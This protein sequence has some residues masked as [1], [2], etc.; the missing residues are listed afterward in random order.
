MKD[1]LK[2]AVPPA[3]AVA[4]VAAVLS[5]ITKD[6]RSVRIEDQIVRGAEIRAEALDEAERLKDE[7]KVSHDIKIACM[8]SGWT[9]AVIGLSPDGVLDGYATA[10]PGASNVVQRWKEKLHANQDEETR[11]RR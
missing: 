5:V 2:F 4:V 6:R 11:A 8:L 10:F 7:A 9:S 1:F 3:L